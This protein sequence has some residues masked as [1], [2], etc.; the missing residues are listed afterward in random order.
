MLKMLNHKIV[1][2]F[3]LFTWKQQAQQAQRTK[4]WHSDTTYIV[5]YGI[6]NLLY[7]CLALFNYLP[8]D[9]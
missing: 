7:S 6:D 9:V 8:K 4:C 1:R 5:K 2:L 3:S